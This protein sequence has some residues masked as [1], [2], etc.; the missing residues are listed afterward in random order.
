M[1]LLFSTLAV[2]PAWKLA[3]LTFSLDNL[4]LLLSN[5]DLPLA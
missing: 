5:L 1:L 4:P 3:S 2:V